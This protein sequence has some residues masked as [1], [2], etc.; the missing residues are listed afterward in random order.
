M[1]VKLT[2]GSISLTFYVHV[3]HQY[4]FAKKSQSQTVTREKLHEALLCE[5]HTRKMLV[6]SNPDHPQLMSDLAN[7]TSQQ[8]MMVQ[9]LKMFPSNVPSPMSSILPR[10]C[11][12]TSQLLCWKK[13]WTTDPVFGLHACP[14]K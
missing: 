11:K 10:T 3:F 8:Q 6:K 14:I 4:P 12:M 9:R 2:P 13:L 1:V 7:M 5:K